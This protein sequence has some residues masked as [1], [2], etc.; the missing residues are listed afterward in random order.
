MV[1]AVEKEYQQYDITENILP[2]DEPYAMDV[3]Y[4]YL[5]NKHTGEYSWY[6]I[7][8][9]K[10]PIT[11]DLPSHF[12]AVIYT[13]IERTG[14]NFLKYSGDSRI[15]FEI[16]TCLVPVYSE[17]TFPQQLALVHQFESTTD[18]YMRDEWMF[19]ALD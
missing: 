2:L 16:V 5:K 4:A 10:I 17:E 18:F 6:F 9:L 12:N 11:D 8:T 15:E 1:G 19:S 13:Q 3:E 7:N 14:I